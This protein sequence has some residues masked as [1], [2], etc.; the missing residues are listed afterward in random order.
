MILTRRSRVP[1]F[2]VTARLKTFGGFAVAPRDQQDQIAGREHG[3]EHVPGQQPL[4]TGVEA[5][6]RRALACTGVLRQMRRP[7]R[8][9]QRDGGA[10]T[11]HGLIEPLFL[12]RVSGGHLGI[13]GHL[14]DPKVIIGKNPAAALV[15]HVVM[16]GR[17]APAH[18]GLLVAPSG[19]RQQPAVARQTAVADVVDEAV[20]LLQFRPQ[21]LAAAEIMIVLPVLRIDLEDHCKHLSLLAGVVIAAGCRRRA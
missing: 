20:D 8:R 15:L 5:Q 21:H 9:D 11:G 4:G 16:V 2:K 6:K 7:L 1:S 10:F 14:S 12:Q 19:Q 13:R 18:H 17:D 3:V